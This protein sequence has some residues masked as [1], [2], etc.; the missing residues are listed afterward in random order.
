VGLVAFLNLIPYM[1]SNQALYRA[2]ILSSFAF[3]HWDGSKSS[4]NVTEERVVEISFIYG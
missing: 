4:K 3:T 1:C 2:F